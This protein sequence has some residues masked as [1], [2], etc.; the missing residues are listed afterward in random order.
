MPE[1]AVIHATSRAIRE[2]ARRPRSENISLIVCNVGK[3]RRLSR[4]PTER[5]LALARP[6][7]EAERTRTQ[8]VTPLTTSLHLSAYLILRQTRKR[9]AEFWE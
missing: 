6:Q 9:E 8:L 4:G 3:I 1:D 5:R 2:L 7:H